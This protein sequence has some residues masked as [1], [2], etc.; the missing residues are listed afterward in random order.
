MNPV[1]VSVIIPAYN[2]AKYIEK[3][4]DSVLVQNVPLEIIVIND[5]STDNIEE[6]MGKYFR[7]ENVIYIKNLR[8]LGAAESRNKGVNIARGEY[9]A[10]LDGDDIW[11]EGKLQKQLELIEE[12]NAVLCTTARQII[13]RKGEVTKKIIPTKT[14]ISYKQLMK[15][16]CISCSSVLLKKTVAQKFP[17]H[18][19][20]CHE[21]YI[22]WLEILREYKFAC[23]VNEP[24]LLYRQS[25]TGK[26]GNK[27]KSAIMTFKV[28]RYLG[29]GLFKSVLC[30]CSYVFNG[31]RKHWLG[32]NKIK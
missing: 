11:R 8:N 4:I 12:S 7:L 23:G 14:V 22:M 18:H 13:N 31:V 28:Y 9:I 6:V 24:L 2:C 1:C 20:D 16:N 29:F 19:D 5:C 26:S 27:L 17:M 21:D 32:G 25:N 10:F 3:A 15:N 30:F